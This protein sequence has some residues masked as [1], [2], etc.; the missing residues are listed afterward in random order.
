MKKFFYIRKQSEG[1]DYTI[2][3]GISMRIINAPSK[4]E[5]VKKIIDLPDN[6]KQELQNFIER[7]GGDIDGYYHDTIADSGLGMIMPD[8]YENKITSAFLLEI[9]DE[10][11]E[12]DMLPILKDK[13]SET[14]SFKK[15][16]LLKSQE[17][18]EREQYEK[19]KKKFDK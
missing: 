10:S 13:L 18:A 14:E 4:E 3:C 1:C 9:S 2:G 11:C 6:W 5:A 17:V 16:L 8:E 19:L 15:E 7:E 12:T